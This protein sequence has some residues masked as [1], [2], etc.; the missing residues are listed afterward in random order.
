MKL[1]RIL[2][3]VLRQKEKNNRDTFISVISAILNYI[4]HWIASDPSSCSASASSSD[5]WPV[6]NK[7][8]CSLSLASISLGRIPE[9]LS[10]NRIALLFL[11]YY[12]NSASPA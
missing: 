12:G 6:N 5:N 9:E 2:Q 3:Y 11:L 1:W 4:H 7:S 8:D 10:T